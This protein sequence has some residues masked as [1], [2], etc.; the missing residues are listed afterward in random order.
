M[1]TITA[2][3]G[4][5]GTLF[6]IMYARSDQQIDTDKTVNGLPVEQI[7]G[8]VTKVL[9]LSK[10][11]GLKQTWTA[12]LNAF[13]PALGLA[14]GG[15]DESAGIIY[16]LFQNGVVLSSEDTGT[17]ALVGRIAKEWASG[18][19]SATLGLPTSDEVPTGLGKEVR[20]QFQGG[21]IVY[22]PETEQIQVF[23]D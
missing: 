6:A 19:N 9:A 18:N 22:N 12:V 17:H 3:V 13:G 16:Q 4:L 15:P 1:G 8:I 2:L 20:V 7:P 5:A 14:V 23:T 21:S 11:E 10:N